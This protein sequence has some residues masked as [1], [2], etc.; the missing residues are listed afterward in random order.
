[1]KATAVSEFRLETDRLVLRSWEDRDIAPF[2]EICCDRNVMATLGPVM[3]LSDTA[4]L[5][6]RCQA[7]QADRGHCF[8]ALERRADARLIGWCGVIRGSVGPI[9]DKPELGWRLAADCWGQG[10]ASEAARATAAWCFANLDDDALWAITSVANIGSRRVMERVGMRYHPE[11]DFDHPRVPADSPLL[12][13]VAY[14]LPR[15]PQSAA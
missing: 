15:P 9:A 12:R 14:S 8:W 5:V 6:A 13:H 4:A 3:N 10:Y 7:E 11:L 2:A 1:M